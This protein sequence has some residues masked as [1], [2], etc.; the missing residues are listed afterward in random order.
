M[1]ALNWFSGDLFSEAADGAM[2]AM[3]GKLANK[4]FALSEEA[5]A[6]AERLSMNDVWTLTQFVTKSLYFLYGSLLAAVLVIWWGSIDYLSIPMQI[7][8]NIY[9]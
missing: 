5:Y 3:N 8:I 9:I 2:E 1:N 4:Y 6:A 7:N